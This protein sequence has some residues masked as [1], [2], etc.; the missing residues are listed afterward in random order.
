MQPSHTPTRADSQVDA[1]PQGMNRLPVLT[2]E[3]RHAAADMTV[4]ARASFESAI[5]TEDA[6]YGAEFQQTHA[7]LMARLETRLIAAKATRAEAEAALP[8]RR[9][10]PEETSIE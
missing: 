4:D 3:I 9:D 5:T 10:V 2:V 7:E 8:L 6:R 1:T